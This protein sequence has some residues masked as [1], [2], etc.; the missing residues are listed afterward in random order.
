L[1]KLNEANLGAVGFGR[2]HLQRFV[3]LRFNYGKFC[4]SPAVRGVRTGHQIPPRAVKQPPKRVGSP[5]SQQL[6]AKLRS[7][8]RLLLPLLSGSRAQRKAK[9]N[10]L[11]RAGYPAIASA[12]GDAINRDITAP[13]SSVTSAHRSVANRITST[14]PFAEDVGVIAAW[15]RD[16]PIRYAHLMEQ[17]EAEYLKANNITLPE[18]SF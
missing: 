14:S 15:M 5:T 13:A 7:L 18:R 4:F 9:V 1:T 10:G 6:A 12:V 8:R 11:L 2:Y 17:V 3:Q 16:R